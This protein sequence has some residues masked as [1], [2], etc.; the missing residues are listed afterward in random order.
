M[1]P[2]EVLKVFADTYGIPGCGYDQDGFCR[3]VVDSGLVI[4]LE[5]QPDGAAVLM[6][7]AVGRVDTGNTEALLSLLG[8]NLYYRP[9]SPYVTALDRSG[10]EVLLLLSL[11]PDQ[12]PESFG[13]ALDAFTAE[14]AAWK[15]FLDAPDFGDTPRT[16]T[17]GPDAATGPLPVDFA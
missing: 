6:Q 9:D 15:E 14:A 7:C 3:L 13:Q 12:T 8:T 17:P 10:G 11:A 1:S 2:K 16:G 5:I 4:D